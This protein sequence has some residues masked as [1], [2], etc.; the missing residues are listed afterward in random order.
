[1]ALIT[2]VES[3]VFQRKA[4]SLFTAKEREALIDFLAANPFAGDEIKG[5]G[6]VRKVRFAIG[7]RGKS[8]GARVIYFIYDLDHPLRLLT[9]YGKNERASISDAEANEFAKV[10]AA[11]KSEYRRRSK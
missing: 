4:A 10:S 3:S 7:G 6:G 2:V 1:M 8:G 5:T 9:C 11:I